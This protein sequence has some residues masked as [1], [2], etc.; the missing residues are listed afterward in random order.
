MAR[1]YGPG[2]FLHGSWILQSPLYAGYAA[3]EGYL[4][5]KKIAVAVAV[6]FTEA[7]FDEH[8]DYRGNASVDL[9]TKIGAYLAPDDAP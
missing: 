3:T 2:V 9:F 4:P 5:S 1:H 8:G 6:T 7:G